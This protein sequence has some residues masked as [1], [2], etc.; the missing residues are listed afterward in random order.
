MNREERHNEVI[1]ALKE[2]DYNWETLDSNNG[3]L[4]HIRVNGIGD[5]WP[6][7]GTYRIGGRFYK[8]DFK[9]LI[10]R[11]TGKLPI[12][13]EKKNNDQIINEL[14]KRVEDLEVEVVY[15]RDHVLPNLN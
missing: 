14:L 15:L 10:Q 8:K 12:K 11:I 2:N 4:I 3:I 7:S 9:G 13:P 5:I 6:T 1:K